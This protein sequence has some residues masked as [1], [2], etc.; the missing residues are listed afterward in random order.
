[1]RL[2]LPAVA[3]PSQTSTR[4]WGLDRMM[5]DSDNRTTRGVVLRYGGF[6]P[7]NGTAA[8]AGLSG[9]TLLHDIVCGYHNPVNSRYTPETLRNDTTA[10][11]LASIYE[12]VWRG[13][14]LT[15]TNGARREF[16]ESTRVG[17]PSMP[18]C[19]PSSTRKPS[20]L[21]RPGPPRC[22]L[23]MSN[24]GARAVATA[25]AWARLR[26]PSN[27]ASR[28]RSAPAPGCSSCRT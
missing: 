25:P 16:L 5:G 6:E 3:A 11:D 12:G 13:Q 18:A 4:E 19:R 1:M 9:T 7:I 26:T 10:R 22:S 14:L 8:W 15:A 28:S 23:S 20:A 17:T 21:A 27:A 24:T 2:S